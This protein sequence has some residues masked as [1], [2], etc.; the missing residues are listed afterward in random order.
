MAGQA[1]E[2]VPVFSVITPTLNAA[3]FIDATLASVVAQGRDD[4]EQIVVDGGSTDATRAIVERYPHARFVERGGSG[5]TAAM[6]AGAA[7][8]RGTFLAFLNADDVLA[9]GALDA[10]LNAFTA[11]PDADVAYGGALHIDADGAPLEPYPTRAFNADLL[12]EECF[13]CQ[14]ATVIR[15]SSFE[16]A[17]GFAESLNFSMD[18][19]LWLRMAPWARF[20]SIDHVTAHARLHRDAKTVAQRA[21]IFRETFDVLRNQIGYVPYTWTY[22]YADHLMQP[23]DQVFAPR[24]RSRLKVAYALALGLQANPRH[25]LRAL[26]DWL[27]HRA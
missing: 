10:L 8:A 25:P 1:I 27:S 19:D 12:V 18:Y 13:I 4:V 2:R 5:Q 21:A 24:R 17:G 16:R 9:P 22:A 15:R 7:L 26:R 11:Q 14:A 23:D 20:I 3:R 6:N